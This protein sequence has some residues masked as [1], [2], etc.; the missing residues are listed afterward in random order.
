MG[1]WPGP[2]DPPPAH[3][4]A[5]RS[6]SLSKD[7]A[8]HA[9]TR[10][11]LIAVALLCLAGVAVTDLSPQWGFRYWA[12]MAGVMAVAGIV[13]SLSRREEADDGP[14]RQ[15]LDQTLH[16]AATL[17]AFGV[18]YVFQS[19]DSVS[20]DEAGLVGLLLIALSTLLAGL[21]FDWRLCVYGLVLFA[22][23]IAGTLI[24]Q[25]F[26]LFVGPAV[27]V[28]GFSLLWRVRDTEASEKDEDTTD[29]AAT[30][31]ETPGR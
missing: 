14:V 31:E 15:L 8:T 7:L 3:T 1:W 25:F 22:A 23:A 4:I 2:E 29:A 27:V 19:Q 10:Q 26:W 13:M 28:I 20:D 30:T 17:L 6:R 16:W 5:A 24:E 12:A 21:R 18:L 9:F 11:T